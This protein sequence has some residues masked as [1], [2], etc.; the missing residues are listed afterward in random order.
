MAEEEVGVISLAYSLLSKDDGSGRPDSG[1][2]D[3]L[4][5]SQCALCTALVL[6]NGVRFRCSWW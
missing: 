4:E 2:S 3:M 5:V 1:L 6:I